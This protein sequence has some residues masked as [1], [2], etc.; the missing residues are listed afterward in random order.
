MRLSHFS[1]AN[2]TA[3]LSFPVA[4]RLTKARNVKNHIG[5]ELC[6]SAICGEKKVHSLARKFENPNAITLNCGGNISA[7]EEYR[8]QKQ[9]EI[10]NFAAR[11]IVLNRKLYNGLNVCIYVSKYPVLYS[12]ISIATPP[13]AVMMKPI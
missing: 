6:I 2:S 5:K 13:N 9:I 11:I 10:P 7:D 8:V 1:F 3:L 12:Y 4:N